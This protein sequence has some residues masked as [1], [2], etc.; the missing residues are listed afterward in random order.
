MN[1][2]KLN[3]LIKK[4]PAAPTPPL[5]EPVAAREPVA[6]L[7]FA[8]L[9]WESTTAAA[10][11]AYAKL[12]EC[13]VDFNDLRVSL[14]AD[15]VAALGPRYPRA[16]ERALRL[17]AALND[18]F[19]REHALRLSAERSGKRDI[20]A[21]VESLE[22]IVV[23]YVASRM[24]LLCYG[25]HGVPVDEQTRDLLVAAG[26]SDAG[27]DPIECGHA[28]ARHVKAEQAESTHS[29]LQA[30][31]DAAHT[32]AAAPATA[33]TPAVPSEARR[34]NARSASKSSEA[35]KRSKRS[36]GGKAAKG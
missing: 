28:L 11:D 9:L 15:I 1:P 30:L 20:K 19:R 21:Y 34:V 14:P 35:P 10:I 26:V 24:L 33:S 31:V 5:P 3:A 23:P 13:A 36:S 7:V 8:F 2:T 32:A 29:A 18:I 4:A 12:A 17:R 6:S 27:I 25:V 16:E 22:G